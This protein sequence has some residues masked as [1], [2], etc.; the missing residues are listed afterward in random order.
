MDTSPPSRPASALSISRSTTPQPDD[1]PF[2]LD[3]SS[4][5]SGPDTVAGLTQRCLDAFAQATGGALSDAR[6]A[7]AMR[8]ITAME[9]CLSATSLNLN[10][11]MEGD[12]DDH[13]SEDTKSLS[14]PLPGAGSP[15]GW[16]DLANF[17]ADAWAELDAHVQETRDRGIT[18]V[19]VPPQ[20]A[21]QALFAGL[22]RLPHLQHVRITLAPDQCTGTLDL[23]Q[24]RVPD[25]VSIEIEGPVSDLTVLAPPGTLIRANAPEVALHKSR[26]L[27]VDG[28]G[29]QA[30]SA[31]TL[32]GAAYHHTSHGFLPQELNVRMQLNGESKF[33]GINPLM[34]EKEGDDIMCRTLGTLWLMERH[35]HRQAKEQARE[36][37]QAGKPFP[38]N[39]FQ[40]TSDI[41]R[42]VT[43]DT[44]REQEALLLH[45]PAQALFDTDNFGSMISQQLRQ[46]SPGETRSFAATTPNH[47][48]GIELRVKE[49]EHGGVMRREYVLNIY[50]PNETTT[51]RRV[52][53]HHPEWFLN[54]S[55]QT[56]LAPDKVARYFPGTP[57]IG[58]LV[59][60]VP[61]EER[62]GPAPAGPSRQT[63]VHV[64][65][66]TT[67]TAKFLYAAANRG[68]T[69]SITL[70][71]RNILASTLDDAQKWHRLRAENFKGKPAL[72]AACTRGDTG[73]LVAYL[74]AL[75]ACPPGALGGHY[76]LNLLAGQQ[77]QI[78][79]LERMARS[80][81]PS[82]PD[83]MIHAYV[84]EI[85]ASSL[86]LADKIALLGRKG[87]FGTPALAA[88]EHAPER[89]AA[90]MCG[91]LDAQQSVNDSLALLESLGVSPQAVEKA[92]ARLHTSLATHAGPAQQDQLKRQAAWSDRLNK[93][94]ADI[95]SR[96][97]PDDKSVSAAG[98]G[99]PG[100]TA[101]PTDA[102]AQPVNP[103]ALAALR[104]ALIPLAS[105]ARFRRLAAGLDTS[106]AGATA[107]A[108]LRCMSP[109][110]RTLDLRMLP[111]PYRELACA[112][113]PAAWHAL[114]QYALAMGGHGMTSIAIPQPPHG[115]PDPVFIS[116][117]LNEVKTLRALQVPWQE[118][119]EF[120]GLA[121]PPGQLTIS[122][123][124]RGFEDD[125]THFVVPPDCKTQMLRTGEGTVTTQYATPLGM[126]SEAQLVA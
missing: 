48:L 49:R 26:V 121:H 105:Q 92:M 32:A 96:A 38:Y 69:G 25:G 36:S 24:L 107:Q 79:V 13:F 83:A 47:M 81:A 64:N 102:P 89:T 53:A 122:V 91:I 71:V 126:L 120:G 68:V 116:E 72:L 40:S 87:E 90:M 3:D 58:S 14:S 6:Q 93:T 125:D 115:R 19:S 5:G 61:P 111:Q 57:K 65:P 17:P 118:V 113:P 2:S 34:S 16:S 97:Q 103:P 15:L 82:T 29:Q 99:K 4:D 63:S 45:T 18:E 55:L 37:K 112:L 11:F 1:A 98:T 59:R 80:K 106:L 84:R 60:W 109:D 101:P 124:N 110:G 35:A 30:G 67:Q 77:D 8:A 88:L 27:Y 70:A 74:R 66:Q 9:E 95:A 33:S 117:G 104:S 75:L 56:W 94:V 119:M 39:A 21:P 46:M 51:H 44:V 52:V 43:N 42:H 41:A 108:L 78:P 12:L 20:V 23:S 76:L 62:A 73:A 50:D 100:T 28:K 86:P 54:H 114:Q 85:A 31:V 7:R 123:D 22:S 10:Y